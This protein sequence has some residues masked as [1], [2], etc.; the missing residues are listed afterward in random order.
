[1]IRDEKRYEMMRV[2][3]RFFALLLCISLL[4]LSLSSCKKQLPKKDLV[5]YNSEA[6][7]SVSFEI[8]VKEGFEIGN[9]S[10]M[11]D[12]EENSCVVILYKK[13]KKKGEI[14]K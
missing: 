2:H 10:V 1:M 5:H 9:Y 13:K 3:T 12:G 14:R 4:P 8:P 6:Y 11:P 7:A